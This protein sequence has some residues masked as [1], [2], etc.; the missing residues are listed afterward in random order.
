MRTSVVFP[1]DYSGRYLNNPSK[2]TRAVGEKTLRSGINVMG[3]TKWRLVID[4]SSTI[5]N[6]M[7][8]PFKMPIRSQISTKSLI[9]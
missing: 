8:K 7:R 1:E 2:D 6:L 9:D 3:K 4:I 5:E